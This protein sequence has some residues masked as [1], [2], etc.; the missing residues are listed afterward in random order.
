MGRMNPHP[1]PSSFAGLTPKALAEQEIREA[2]ER[3]AV[4]VD[5]AWA[6][7]DSRPRL[8]ADDGLAVWAARAITL[9]R[10]PAGLTSAEL[11]DWLVA[12]W[13]SR[14]AVAA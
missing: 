11:D 12:G 9:G 3:S 13:L 8:L 6:W 1:V 5:R 2:E 7:I 10:T 14:Q 4:N